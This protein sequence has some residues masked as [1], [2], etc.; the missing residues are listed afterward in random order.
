M[1]PTPNIS[2]S[3]GLWQ[4]LKCVCLTNSLVILMPLVGGQ[5][6]R[7]CAIYHTSFLLNSL[8]LQGISGYQ[9]RLWS[10]PEPGFKSQFS[11]LEDL[12]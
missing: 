5:V 6:L 12:R 11:N 4:D 3:A 8:I 10:H 2:D 1:G 7:T 9:N